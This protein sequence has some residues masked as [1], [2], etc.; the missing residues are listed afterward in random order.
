MALSQ[1]H[2]ESLCPTPLCASARNAWL[3][4]RGRALARRGER[5]AGAEH[6]GGAEHL[7]AG[8]VRKLRLLVRREGPG[9]S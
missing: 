8:A 3:C 4:L 5:Q 7:R 9:C 6:G 1:S 2:A